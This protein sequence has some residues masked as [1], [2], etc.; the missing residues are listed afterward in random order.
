VTN[1]YGPDHP[2]GV[3]TLGDLGPWQYMLSA[4]VA[5]STVIT[6]VRYFVASTLLAAELGGAADY[7]IWRDGEP[8]SVVTGTFT[9]PA[10]VG[11]ITDSL[12]TP[13]QV[14]SGRR[15]CLAISLDAAVAQHAGETPGVMP[16]VSGLITC[17][18]SS[19][20]Q[21]TDR[22]Y[23]FD[24]SSGAHPNDGSRSTF[25]LD[26]EFAVSEL[27]DLDPALMTAGDVV[28]LTQQVRG[29][30]NSVTADTDA[31]IANLHIEGGPRD[32]MDVDYWIPDTPAGLASAT[33]TLHQELPDQALMSVWESSGG[34]L[35]TYE[36]GGIYHCGVG[37]TD[38]PKGTNT[39]RNDTPS[40][41]PYP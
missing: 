23:T 8:T 1:I 34:A 17:H 14:P 37:G 19:A 41:V 6:H 31:V 2:A 3:L 15:M 40:L 24:P 36:G 16:F 18:G 28:L 39:T 30:V 9:I 38:Y 4:S 20:Y 22:V 7:Q 32:G 11:W 26:V 12:A 27:V 25:Y 10:T 21:T 13:L 5:A 33:M 35:W 29:E